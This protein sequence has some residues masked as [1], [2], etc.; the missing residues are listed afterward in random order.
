[1][2]LAGTE[3]YRDLAHINNITFI[4]ILNI[5]IMINNS[6]KLTFSKLSHLYLSIYSNW[7]P[8]R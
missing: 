4:Y 1:M 8:T 2:V 6:T 7:Q 5:K 3:L